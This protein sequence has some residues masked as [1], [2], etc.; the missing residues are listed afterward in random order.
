[1]QPVNK[2]GYHKYQDGVEGIASEFTLISY[3]TF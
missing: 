1:M 2:I 3:L